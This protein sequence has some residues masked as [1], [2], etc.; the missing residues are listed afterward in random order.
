MKFAIVSL[1]ILAAV[2]VYSTAHG[3]KV[4]AHIQACSGVN[5][6][7]KGTIKRIFDNLIKR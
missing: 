3:N 6:G 5:V 1:L 4:S 7:G 2:G